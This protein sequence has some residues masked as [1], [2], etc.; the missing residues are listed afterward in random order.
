MSFD[1]PPVRVVRA[2]GGA[3]ELQPEGTDAGPIRVRRSSGGGMRVEGAGIEGAW[4]L[5]RDDGPTGGFQVVDDAESEELGRSV[6]MGQLGLQ[7]EMRYVL[8][9]DGNLFREQE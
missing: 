4:S 7:R 1:H 6:G 9:G 3:F 8:L 2:G 5:R